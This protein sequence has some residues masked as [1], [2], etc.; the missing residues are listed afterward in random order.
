MKKQTNTSPDDIKQSIS[1]IYSDI[2]KNRVDE[3][4]K[5]AEDKRL[6]KE[7]KQ[8]EEANEAG[9][10]SS[11]EEDGRPLTK[12]EKQERALDS[13]KDVIG[14]LTGEDLDYI[15]P[16]KS[17]KKYK[18]WIDEDSDGNA[19]LVEKPKKK[20]KSNYNK[21]FENELNMLKSI[22]SDQNKFTDNL[23][24]RFNTMVGPNT[25]DAMPLNKTSVELAAAVI[26]SRSNA[27]AV[28]KEIG[29]IKKTIA[30][31]YMKDKK[32]QQ[33]LGGSGF[34]QQ[35]LTLV[36]SSIA[37]AMMGSNYQSSTPTGTP[38]PAAP[39][40]SSINS[41]NMVFEDFDPQ[42]FA[43]DNVPV[44]PYVKYENVAKKTLIEFDQAENKHR[45]KTVDTNTGE[46]IKDYP[47]P[48]FQ[49]KSIDQKNK[50]AK[51]SFDS[52]YD[53][54]IINANQ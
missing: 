31:L 50:V 21:E 14:N 6:A 49:I 4:N 25:K 41:G 51:D 27:L 9:D 10:G 53:V 16:K 18:K 20:K 40:N 23:Q 33:E 24:K 26:S 44:D 17:K 15:T 12:K 34:D 48:T 1:Q 45:Y 36:G 38:Q 32:L 47:N 28:I 42:K 22:V 35:D 3:R 2:L 13:W 39:T 5:V 11:Q 43:F 46:E 37:S 30:D 19:I 29:N 54:E 8:A 7:T 52:I